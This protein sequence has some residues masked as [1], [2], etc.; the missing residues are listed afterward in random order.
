MSIL[1]NEHTRVM[2][3]GLTGREGGFHAEQMIAYGTK[4]VAGVTPGK[5]GTEHLGVPVF[6][7]VAEAL[8]QART[9]PRFLCRRHLPQMQCSKPLMRKC[10]WWSVSP[11]EFRRWT[12]CALRQCFEIRKRG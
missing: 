6:N 9:R 12:W 10:R 7:T 2:V 3:Q 1:V 4:I 8:R 11:R 5:G